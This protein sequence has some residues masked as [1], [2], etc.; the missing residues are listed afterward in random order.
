MLFLGCF[1]CYARNTVNPVNGKTMQDLY[2]GTIKKICYLKEQGF[3]IVEMW[4]CNLKKELEEDEE[5]H[6]YFEEHNL[7]DPL[8]PCDAFL[9]D[10]QMLQSYFT[11][12]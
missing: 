11:N 5:M 12:V 1:T 7:V 6:R 3:N 9:A 4:E 2:E 10:V 8:Q